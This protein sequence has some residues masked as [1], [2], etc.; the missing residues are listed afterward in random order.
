VQ[1]ISCQKGVFSKKIR[2]KSDLCIMKNLTPKKSLGQH[3]LNDKGIAAKIVSPLQAD[4]I[5]HVIEVGPGM[6][7]LTPFLLQ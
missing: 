4:G 5:R 7:A 1:I 3:F 2:K 6:G